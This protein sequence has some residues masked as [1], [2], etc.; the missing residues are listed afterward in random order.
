[1]G[2]C[3]GCKGA[4]RQKRCYDCCNGTC[5]GW[6]APTKTRLR[7][8]RGCCHAPSGSAELGLTS[9][10]G[11]LLLEMSSRRRCCLRMGS[12]GEPEGADAAV[13]PRLALEPSERVATVLSLAEILRE[14][15]A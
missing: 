6:A 15:A 5:E 14:M 7:A 13:A 11:K 4:K 9:K 8:M 2:G 1:L 3:V 10:C 12:I